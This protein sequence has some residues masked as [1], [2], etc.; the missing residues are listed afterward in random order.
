MGGVVG[1]DA[2]RDVDAAAAAVELAVAC[3]ETLDMRALECAAAAAAAAVPTAAAGAEPRGSAMGGMRAYLAAVGAA[4]PRRALAD[5]APAAAALVALGGVACGLR[6][7][8]VPGNGASAVLRFVQL[9]ATLGLKRGGVCGAPWPAVASVALAAGTLDGMAA[10]RSLGSLAA[11]VNAAAAPHAGGG[12]RSGDAA[13]CED[14]AWAVRTFARCAATM[15]AL[16]APVA[17]AALQKVLPMMARDDELGATAPLALAAFAGGDPGALGWVQH[18]TRVTALHEA[19]AVASRR[20]LDGAAAAAA[21]WARATVLARAADGAAA[22]CASDCDAGDARSE[23]RGGGATEVSVH[24]RAPASA[25]VVAIVC[26]HATRACAELRARRDGGPGRASA[27]RALVVA[28]GALCRCE[29]VPRFALGPFLHQCV[30]ADADLAPVCVAL[31]LAHCA[32]SASALAFL[33]AMRELRAPDGAPASCALGVGATPRLV[34]ARLAQFTRRRGEENERLAATS[35]SYRAEAGAGVRAEGAAAAVMA[36][37][38]TVSFLY[39]PL[40]FTRI[41]LT[42]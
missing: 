21:T 32:L 17:D 36:D 34:A 11:A 8:A 40:H 26:A 6:V 24:L 35:A 5:A 15:A 30:A 39:V 4:A 10:R 1:A 25:P 7:L 22:R 29:S 20:A 12:P 37:I 14:A 27:R 42:F 38:L 18:A 19:A 33:A 3:G 28:L 41:M 23:S 31:A 16:P 13:G 2:G 9:L